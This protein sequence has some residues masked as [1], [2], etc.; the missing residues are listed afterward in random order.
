MSVVYGSHGV[1]YIGRGEVV[2]GGYF[3]GACSAAV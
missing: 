1:D 3:C 2:R